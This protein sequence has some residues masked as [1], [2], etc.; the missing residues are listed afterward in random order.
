M[1]LTEVG[2]IIETDLDIKKSD[3]GYSCDFPWVEVKN[4]GCLSSPTGRGKTEAQARADL[5]KQLA[6]QRIVKYAYRAS[7]KEYQLPPKI[8]GR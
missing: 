5:A 3:N 1:T 7:R 4:G 8:T 2:I 6:G